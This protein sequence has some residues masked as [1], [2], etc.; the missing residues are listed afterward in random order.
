MSWDTFEL[1]E[2][3]LPHIQWRLNC[4]F[5]IPEN[6]K[7]YKKQLSGVHG[8]EELAGEWGCSSEEIVSE[9]GEKLAYSLDIEEIYLGMIDYLKKHN[10]LLPKNWTS[11]YECQRYYW[12]C[13]R[14][15][16]ETNPGDAKEYGSRISGSS[17]TYNSRYNYY[18]TY[19]NNRGKPTNTWSNN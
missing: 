19:R 18:Y 16:W 2:N 15:E 4:R 7:K 12:N 5:I 10:E 11:F 8:G 6:T 17:M 3:N 13:F 1:Q 14:I 9:I